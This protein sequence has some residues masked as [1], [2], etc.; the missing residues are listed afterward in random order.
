MYIYIHIYV[1]IYTYIHMYM[2]IHI[3]IYTY[4]SICIY[5]S[6]YIP[7]G[8]Y[9]PPRETSLPPQARA[10]QRPTRPAFPTLSYLRPGDTQQHMH[11]RYI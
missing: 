5:I 11:R 1:Y 8:I 2:Y 7:I 4:S 9:D 3:N 6:I 10:G